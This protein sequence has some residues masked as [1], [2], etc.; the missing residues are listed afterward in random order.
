MDG[1]PPR[2]FEPSYSV[3]VTTPIPVVML[4]CGKRVLERMRRGRVP[5]FHKGK[6]GDWVKLRRST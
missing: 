1:P 5:S 3:T 6:L 4:K 2:N